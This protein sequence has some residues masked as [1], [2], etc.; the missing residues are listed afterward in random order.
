M[1]TSNNFAQYQSLDLSDEIKIINP[2]ITPF[3]TFLLSNGKTTKATSNII[4]W[5][6]ETLN[7]DAIHVS[8]EGAD[9]PADV[10]D[11]TGL[12]SNYVELITGTAKVSNT[13]Q[14]SEIVGVT[15]LMA[16]EV[17][18]KLT[19]LKYFEEKELMLGVKA[20]ATSSDG[21]KMNGLLNM[22]HADNVVN[23]TGALTKAIFEAMLKKMYDSGT[24]DNMICFIDDTNKQAVN[25][26]IDPRYMAK[27]N[28]IGFTCDR[29]HTDYGDVTFVLTPSLSGAKS[30]T[31]VNPDYLELK[32]LHSAQAIDL[33]ITGDSISKMV[34]WEGCLKLG[35]SKAASKIVFTA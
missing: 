25:S 10:Q 4:N 29:Y 26:F 9:A 19:L 6:E 7:T 8:K 13:A 31:V 32:E 35:N 15:D 1:Y 24:S 30:F 16:R 21:Q 3:T 33:A 2:Q 20:A 28:F 14:A 18:K 23:A 17:N 34:K 11:S 27:D 5:Y 12:L 22:I